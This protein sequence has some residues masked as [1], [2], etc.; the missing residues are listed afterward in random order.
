MFYSTE[1]V[2]KLLDSLRHSRENEVVEYKEAKSTFGD[3]ELGKY[4]SALS[5]EALLRKKTD[6]WLFFGITNDF[7]EVC[8]T[9]YRAGNPKALQALKRDMAGRTSQRLTFREIHELQ[10]DGKRVIAFQI[11]AATPGIPT[12]YNDA[13]WARE[14]ESCAPLPTSKYEEIRQMKRPD[15]S[16]MPVDGATVDDLSPEAV[17]RAVELFLDKHGRFRETFTG[18]ETLQMLDAAGITVNGKITPTALI[19]LGKP[20]SA[21]YMEG[22]SPRIT[23]TL[24]GA[25]GSVISYEHFEPPLLLAVDK[26]L[27]KIRNEKYRFLANGRSLFPVELTQYEPDIIRELLHNCIAH[28]DYTMQGRVNVE[29]FEDHLVFMNEGSFIPES[30]ELAMVPGYKPN[31][32][33]NP[34]LCE[35]MVQLNMIDTIAMGIPKMFKMQRDRFFPLP[36]YDFENPNRVVVSIFGKSIN[37]SY[38]RLLYARPDLDLGVVYLL[39]KVQKG[40]EI[41]ADQAAELHA[42]GL[43]EG[44]WPQL[45]IASDI[46]VQTDSRAEYVR[47]KGLNDEACKQ[48]ILQMLR[49]TGPAKRGQILAMLD[50]LLPSG[51]SKYQ[52]AR[53]VSNLLTEMKNGDVSIVNEGVGKSAVWSIL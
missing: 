20:G 26:V 23:W 48:L 14:D 10:Y 36:T 2:I 3:K 17:E 22:I 31:Y 44:R 15:W 38:S 30:I 1:D 37:E 21:R 49:E 13:C 32:Y 18:M 34:A 39:D 28:Q 8:G 29:E 33:R 41:T 5:N 53:K 50:D 24:Y 25:D 47:S 45:T 43:V 16:A 11:P 7:S 51:M 12:S 6:A 4:L 40:E 46:A 52:K 42:M 27:D 9:N 19:L 35:A